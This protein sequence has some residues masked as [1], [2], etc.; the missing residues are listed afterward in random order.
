MDKDFKPCF[1]YIRNIEVKE[2]VG[3][4]TVT[5][6]PVGFSHLYNRNLANGTHIHNCYELSVVTCG[7]GEFI[8]DG[9][10]Y[11]IKEGDILIEDPGIP[12]EIRLHSKPDNICSEKLYYAFFL[13]HIYMTSGN[14]GFPETS[15]ADMIRSFLCKH[16]FIK[17]A[18]NYIINY[19]NFMDSYSREC[20]DNSYGL[21]NTVKNMVFECL[22]VLANG[23]KQLYTV[24]TPTQ[25]IIDNAISYIIRNLHKR[26]YIKDIAQNSFTSERNLQLLFRKHLNKSI[27]EYI[28]I[29]KIATAES[30]LKMNYKVSDT[31]LLVG[32]NDPAQFSRV[33]KKYMGISPK[34]YQLL[35]NTSGMV[36]GANYF[37]REKISGLLLS[38]KK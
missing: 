35:G 24:S 3:N 30:Y 29:R 14:T 10:I 1:N 21:Y 5:I 16:L 22:S 26:I 12:H 34:K 36:N 25:T 11:Q 37:I 33:F 18:Q 9:T 17:T 27:V 19:L 32:I 20:G 31:C 2:S 23:K 4:Y 28:S 8:R 15:E 38:Q 7:T 6:K 13:V